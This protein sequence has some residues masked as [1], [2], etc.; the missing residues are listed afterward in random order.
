MR[1][2]EDAEL[3]QLLET[4]RR[5]AVVG[6]SANAARPSYGVARYLI[7]HGYEIIPVN[8]AESEILGLRCYPDLASIPG[9]VDIVDV[10]RKAEDVLP[11][12]QE[13]VRIGAKSLWLQLGVI[14]EAAITLADTAG[15][16]LVVDRCI[17]IEHA[18]LMR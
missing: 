14:N 8:P 3:Q 7:D 12:A 16:A 10:F 11:I 13:A 1:L 2:T 18:R 17:K 9:A 6:L 4:H 5:I 15:L